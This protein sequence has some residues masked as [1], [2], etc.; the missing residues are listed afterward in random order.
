[1]INENKDSKNLTIEQVLKLEQQNSVSNKETSFTLPEKELPITNLTEEE[2]VDSLDD[3]DKLEELARS[4]DTLL[5]DDI[6]FVRSY[7]VNK[8]FSLPI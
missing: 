5:G 1:M 7:R 4:T 6:S 8:S 3:R 2:V